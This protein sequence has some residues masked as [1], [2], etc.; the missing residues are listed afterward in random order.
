MHLDMK[1]DTQDW[2]M[3]FSGYV[4][5]IQNSLGEI[6]KLRSIMLYRSYHSFSSDDQW[7]WAKLFEAAASIRQRKG[8]K[9]VVLSPAASEPEAKERSK[10]AT[11]D[12][13]KLEFHQN[14][15]TFQDCQL[16]L[17]PHFKQ[18]SLVKGFL[19]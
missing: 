19:W 16:A 8:H 7:E 10:E 6:G 9:V 5:I 18:I 17:A 2:S 13:I 4:V 12:S 11:G 1:W 3:R 15:H 14:G